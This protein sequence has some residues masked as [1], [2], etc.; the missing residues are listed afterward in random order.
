MEETGCFTDDSFFVRAVDT[1]AEFHGLVF[2]AKLMKHGTLLINSNGVLLQLI[3]DP[4]KNDELAQ[5][6]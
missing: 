5:V 1:Y 4:T 2:P 6:K 3:C